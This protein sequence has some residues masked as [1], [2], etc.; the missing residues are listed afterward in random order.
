[1][2]Q[3]APPLQSVP[4]LAGDYDLI[5]LGYQVWFLSPSL[6]VTAFLDH[7]LVQR[8]LA[9][10]PMVVVGA[11]RNMRMGAWLKLCARL[12]AIGAR[13][14]DHAVLVDEG[15]TLATFITTP[16]WLLTGRRDAPWGMPSAGVSDEQ[17][18]ATGRFGHALSGALREGREQ[19]AE[20][21]L[22]CWPA[23][24]RLCVRTA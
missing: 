4:P 12:E 1:M 10:K 18:A 7:P 11:C 22:A 15:P 20:P 17:I 2:Q 8:L 23:S 16:R 5:V 19:G 9:R 14:L 13:M 21:L 24:C 3:I 6:P